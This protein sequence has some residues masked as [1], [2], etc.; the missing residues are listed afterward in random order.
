MCTMHAATASSGAAL[1]FLP[2]VLYHCF[3]LTV[4]ILPFEHIWFLNGSK[5]FPSL[6]E[7]VWRSKQRL[8]PF[9]ISQECDFTEAY[10]SAEALIAVWPQL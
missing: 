4:L 2:T 7:N 9:R 6:L 8:F 5:R 1:Q 3:F 10:L